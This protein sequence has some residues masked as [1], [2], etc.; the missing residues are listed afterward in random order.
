M[1][2]SFLLALLMSTLIPISASASDYMPESELIIHAVAA[3]HPDADL[4]AKTAICAVILNRVEAGGFGD[5]AAAVIRAHDSGLDPTLLCEPI[6][7][8]NYRITRDAYLAASSGADPTGGMLYFEK[9]PEPSRRD[10][11]VEFSEE[12]DLDKYSAVISGYGFY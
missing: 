9:L 7:E 3:S 12:M 4:G 2:K 11:R 1:K 8:K 5:T 10:N 6:G